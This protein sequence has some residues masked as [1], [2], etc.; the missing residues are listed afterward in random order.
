LRGEGEKR[1]RGQSLANPSFTINL[2]NM[3]KIDDGFYN[4]ISKKSKLFTFLA[5]SFFFIAVGILMYF[6]KNIFND[7]NTSFYTFSTIVQGFLALIGFLGT[8]II[9]RLQLIENDAQSTSDNL[10]PFV[11]DYRGLLTDSYSWIEMMNECEKISEIPDK[12]N[13]FYSS[14]IK[15]GYER[16]SKLNKEKSSIRNMMVDFSLLSLINIVLALIGIP[17]S[18]FLIIHSFILADGIYLIINITLSYASV[19]SAFRLIRS[20]LGYS[21]KVKL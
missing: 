19:L 1:A 15:V 11:R 10:K 12:L 16:L 4:Y 2:L 9:F 7:Q 18:R 8:V 3:T 5:N 21:F 14:K 6:Y 17:L 20:C 13:S